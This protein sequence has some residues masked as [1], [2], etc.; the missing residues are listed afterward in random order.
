LYYP[1]P[2]ETNYITWSFK[3]L[4]LTWIRFIEF[5]TTWWL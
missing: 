1:G 2:G 5:S 4:F 3:K